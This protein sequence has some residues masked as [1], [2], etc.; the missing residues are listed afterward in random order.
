M[1]KIYESMTS[2]TFFISSIK[3]STGWFKYDGEYGLEE[4]E[5]FF[6]PADSKLH[7]QLTNS[8]LK[9]YRQIRK[10]HQEYK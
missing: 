4:W 9:I 7:K 3:S 5:P 8:G 1:I 2:D 6:N 10:A